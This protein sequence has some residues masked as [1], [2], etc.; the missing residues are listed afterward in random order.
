M[1]TL[2]FT[3]KVFAILIMAICCQFSSKMSAQ[4]IQIDSLFTSDGE[5]FPFGPN[6]TIYG[7]S[8]SGHVTLSSDTSLVR[9]ILTDNSGNEWMMYEAYPFIN[10]HWDFDLNEMADETMYRQIFDPNSLKIQILNASIYINHLTYRDE[11]HENLSGM[12]ANFKDYIESAKVDSI[13]ESIELNQMLWFANRT[14]V[15]DLTYI[16]KKLSFGDKYNLIGLDYYAG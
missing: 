15:S 4:T 2:I 6:D 7:L 11:Y 3:R 1:K 12:Q 9:V 10:P 16:D 13:N 5:I 8:I 14:P